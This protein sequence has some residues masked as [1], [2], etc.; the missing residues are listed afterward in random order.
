MLIQVI[1]LAP[2]ALWCMYELGAR[3]GGRVDRLLGGSPLD[4]R[5]VRRGPALRPPLSRPL[6]RPVP[7]HAARAD[8]DG[9]LRRHRRLLAVSRLRAYAPSR[10]ATP[11]TAV[12]AGLT[13][14]FAGRRQAIQPDL[15]RRSDRSALLAARRW[16]E[17]PPAPR[18]RP[19][20][21]RTR[22][23]EVPRLRLPTGL[24]VRRGA[25]GARARHSPSSARAIRRHR[26]AAPEKEP[27]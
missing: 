14:G 27:R 24:C 4:A 6:R 12:L 5:A 20:G 21:A 10:T 16:R 9:R 25:G 19:R 3:I 22:P 13:A 23:L 2:I 17:L 18:P 7:P 8:G 11:D 15:P 26:L 1:V